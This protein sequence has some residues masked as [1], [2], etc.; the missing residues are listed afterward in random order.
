MAEEGQDGNRPH[1]QNLQGL[2]QM[3][4]EAGTQSD[5]TYQLE[6]M[7]E[8]RRQWLQ[9]AMSGTFAGQADEVKMIKE[10]L[11]ELSRETDNGEGEEEREQALELL[12]DLCEN[13][14]NASDFCK[15]GGM[16]LL[17]TRYLNCPKAELRWRSAD[18]IGI[19]SQNVPFVQEMALNLGAIRNLLQLLDFD[20]N[21]Q[22][23]IKALFAISCLV[24]EQEVGLAEFLKQDGFS[25]LMRAMQSDVQKLKI[26]AAFL[27]QNLLQSHPEYK[28]TLCSMGMVQQLVSLLRADHSPFHE[29]VLGALCSLVTDFPQGVKACQTPELEFEELLKERCNLV[30]K[31]E[32]FKSWNTVN[33]F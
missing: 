31:Q 24:R 11:Q 5:N 32:E 15:L 26:K 20:C 8:E 17:L 6:Q 23:R 3:A 4:I 30:E 13:L 10:C 25:V 16:N 29:H 28:G 1:R 2:L 21:D 22:V 19:C 14:D 12:A 18:L 33:N 7:S 27:L 9:E